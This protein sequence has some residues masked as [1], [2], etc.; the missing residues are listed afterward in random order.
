MRSHRSW[1]LS[2]SILFILSLILAIANNQPYFCPST[3]WNNKAITVFDSSMIGTNTTGLFVDQNNAVYIVD[4][5]SDSIR[6]FPEE[7]F[8]TGRNLTG[9][10]ADPWSVIAT[11]DGTVYVDNGAL[12]GRVDVWL[13]NSSTSRVVMNVPGACHSLFIDISNHIYCSATH[14]HQVVKKWLSDNSNSSIRIAGTGFSGS[15]AEMLNNPSGVFVDMNYDLYVGDCGNDR[16]QKFPFGQATAITVAGN[17][18][19]NTATFDC[20]NA[21]I[22]DARGYL[23]F[24]SNNNDRIYG[25]GPFGFRCLFGCSSVDGS[26]ENQL[27]SPHQISFDSY[28]NLFVA[29]E[30]N[31][32]IQKFLLVSNS[33]S[34]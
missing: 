7:S 17:G 12:N 16:V 21:V 18:A 34:K 22:L 31:N 27:N 3:T 30:L 6:V 19:P 4:K 24:T 1:N 9:D 23:F 33:C 26:G 10:L 32:R 5:T 28:G 15:S 8:T 11:N 20:P 14:A 25:Q 29:D 2:N 13:L